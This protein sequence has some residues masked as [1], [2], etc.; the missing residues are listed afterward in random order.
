MNGNAAGKTEMREK[1]V[2]KRGGVVM[3]KKRTV[4]GSTSDKEKDKQ[5]TLKTEVKDSTAI[6]QR[7]NII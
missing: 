4:E 5:R 3:E 1:Q 6:N 2:I 7:K